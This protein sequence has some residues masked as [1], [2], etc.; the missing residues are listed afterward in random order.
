MLLKIPCWE[1]EA[2]AVLVQWLGESQ[3]DSKS[4]CRSEHTVGAWIGESKRHTI[5]SLAFLPW[6]VGESVL[7][8][9]GV[10]VEWAWWLAGIPRW[11]SMWGKKRMG[12]QGWDSDQLLV[13]GWPTFASFFTMQWLPDFGHKPLTST[14]YI[15]KVKRV[16]VLMP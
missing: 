16:A 10:T 12:Y 14:V 13:P 11:I 15:C 7:R 1:D 3:S 5:Q 2:H 9:M 8:C 4:S 6:R